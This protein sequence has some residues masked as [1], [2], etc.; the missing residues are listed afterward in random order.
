MNRLALYLELAKARIVSMVLVTTTLGFFLGGKGI[1]PWPRFLLAL[2]GVGCATGGA[3]MLNNYLER[4]FDAKMK[5]TCHRA[6]PAGLI[7]PAMALIVGVSLVL[8]GV[9][10]LVLAANL[11]AAFLVLLAA[12]LYVLVYTPLKRVTW[13]STTFGAIPGAIPPMAS[14]AAATGRLDAG[15]W[16]LFAILFAWQHPH[17]FAIAWMFRDDY[18]TAGFKMLPVIEPTGL[19]TVRLTVGFSLVLLAVSLIPTLIG[20]AGWLY[21]SGALLIGFLILGVALSFARDC[22]VGNA[23]RLLKSSILYLPLLLLLILVDAGLKR[24]GGL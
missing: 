4:N 21:F 5:R 13:L 14:W 12:F 19:R 9:F 6:L 7:E 18:R 22:S 8:F 24:L 1:H 23:R 15:A 17:F 3:L 10:L 11:L 20:M 16:A 2:T